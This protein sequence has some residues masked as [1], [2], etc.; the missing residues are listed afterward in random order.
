MFKYFQVQAI[1]MGKTLSDLFQDYHELA[2]FLCIYLA[3]AHPKDRWSLGA[4]FSSMMHHV[5]MEQRM[6]AAR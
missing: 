2:N 6:D 1:I 3:E 4:T 5:T